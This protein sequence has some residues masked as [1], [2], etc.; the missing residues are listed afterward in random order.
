MGN[1]FKGVNLN[2]N[3]KVHNITVPITAILNPYMPQAMPI[4]SEQKTNTMSRCWRKVV[5]NRMM[6]KAPKMPKPL[7]TLSPMANT[8]IDA[9]IDPSIRV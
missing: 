5:L 3:A 8:M 1:P 2:N 6:A 9:P 4:P 7:P